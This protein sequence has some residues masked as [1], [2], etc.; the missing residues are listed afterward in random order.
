VITLR[1]PKP[2]R[3]IAIRWK[4]ALLIVAV[5]G[6]TFL[7]AS[8][9]LLIDMRANFKISAVQELSVL[10]EAVGATSAAALVFD[11]RRALAETLAAMRTNEAVLGAALYD[12]HARLVAEYRRA[13]AVVELPPAVLGDTTGFLRER[14]WVAQT[15]VW[16][17]RPIGRIYLIASTARWNEALA[18]FLWV[19][20]V[21]F[22]CALATSLVLSLRLQTLVT[23]PIAQLLDLSRR[24]AQTRDYSVRAVK[25]GDDELGALVDGFNHMLGQ[26]E[27]R[28]RDIER[29]QAELNQRVQ[30]LADEVAERERTE[31]ELRTS[32]Q[33]LADFVDNASVGLHWLDAD[34]VIIWANR[35]ELTLLGYS[36]EEYVGYPAS[37][38]HADAEALGTL[39]GHIGRREPLAN[40]EARLRC[41]DGTT[42][43]V[44]IDANPYF[45]NGVFVHTRVFTRDITERKRAEEALRLSEMRER[46]RAAELGII[47]E[48][49]PAAVFI[50]HDTESRRI[51]TNRVGRELLRLAPGDNASK[52]APDGEAPT[53]FEVLHDGR[54][55]APHELPVQRAARDGVTIENF[56]EE[57]VYADGTRRYLLGNAVP[58][59]ADDGRPRGAVAAFVDITARKRAEEQFRLAVESAPNGML[60]VDA[61]GTIV[62]INRQLETMF[63]YARDELIGQP[64]ERLV[65][66]SARAMHPRM[67][68][69]FFRDPKARPMGGGRDL[70]GRHKDGRPVAVE[71]GLNPFATPDGMYCLASIIDITA[72]KRAEQ[73]LK[74][75]NEELQ[76]SNRELGQFAYVASHDLQEPLRAVSGCVQL[77]AQRYQGKLDARAD[78]LIGHAVNGA[79]RMQTLINDLLVYSRVGT[80]ARAFESCDCGELLEEALANLEV[81]VRETEAVITHDPLPTVAGDPTQLTQL[82]QNLIGNALKFRGDKRPEVH[83]GVERKSNGYLFYVRDNGIGIEPQYFERVFGVFQRLHSRRE[84]P[85]NGIGL[86]I[87]RKIVERHHGRMWVDSMPGR[88]STFFFTIPIGDASHASA[89]LQQQAH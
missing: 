38:F 41:R 32:R 2:L 27:Q 52:S 83:I 74:R 29:A 84:Y 77:L 35:F 25:E 3:D 49:V 14:V 11:D 39:I 37:A 86:A 19:L 15:I 42:R 82:F 61:R 12:A 71:I 62:L 69:G 89:E 31:A 40:L 59:L 4:L 48:A 21:L 44:L 8:A 36:R 30:E 55:L 6:V 51:T 81:T 17:D 47:V 85:G 70:Y 58:L 65:P 72:R 79:S 56:E 46:A 13:D 88:G 22:V 16:R 18:R 75:F 45:E 26:I 33:T 57:I 20:G 63:G 66:E 34:G 7:L 53:N 87:C 68:A 76:R 9:A 1:W 23:R 5:S 43:F 67:L 60:V 80:R 54:R 73:D 28:R 24:V 50:A 64:I 78:D 10:A